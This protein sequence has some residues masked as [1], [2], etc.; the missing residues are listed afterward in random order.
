MAKNLPANSRDI[1]EPGWRRSPGGGHGNPRVFLPGKP[2][3]QR[4]LAGYS[5]WGL[6]KLD[7]TE[8]LSSSSS[9]SFHVKQSVSHSF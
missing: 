5:P 8:I 7:M 4:S 2:Q 9:N 3:G 6:T 1:R